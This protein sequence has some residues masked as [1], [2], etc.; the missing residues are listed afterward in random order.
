M[1]VHHGSDVKAPCLSLPFGASIICA[2]KHLIAIGTLMYLASPIRFINN[3]D[4]TQREE[5]ELLCKIIVI[6]L[7]VCVCVKGSIMIE[8]SGLCFY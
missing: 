7:F 3:T 1:P 5:N 2:S 4:A 8:I 6:C